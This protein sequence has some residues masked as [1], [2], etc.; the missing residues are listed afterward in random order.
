MTSRLGYSKVLQFFA[1]PLEERK[2]TIWL[3][4]SIFHVTGLLKKKEEFYRFAILSSEYTWEI[5]PK[6][7]KIACHICKVFRHVQQNINV[8][9]LH[10]LHS[11]WRNKKAYKTEVMIC[12][13][14][15]KLQNTVNSKQTHKI[16]HWGGKIVSAKL[17]VKNVSES[18][19]WKIWNGHYIG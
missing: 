8:H 12:A 1:L 9:K 16:S 6:S 11:K 4:F 18:K 17:P 2:I 13:Q 14:V 5:H 15:R 10:F 3:Y 19:R 7:V